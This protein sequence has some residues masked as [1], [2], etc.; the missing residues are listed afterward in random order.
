MIEVWVFAA[1]GLRFAVPLILAAMAGLQSERSGVVNIALE[2]K[3]LNGACFAAL[4]GVIFQNPLAA[5]AG[6]ILGAVIL[7]ALHFWLTQSF[8]MDHIISGM[9]INA[10]ALGGT[11]ILS[12]KA[13]ALQGSTRVPSLP[14]EAFWVIALLTVIGIGWQLGATKGGLRLLAVGNDPDKARQMGVD[15]WPVRLK[16]LLWTGVFCGIAGA[17]L[18]ATA[19]S[20]SKEMTSGRGF[21]ALAALILAGWRPW[22]ALAACLVFG[23]VQ[24]LQL[25]LQNTKVAGFEFPTELFTALPYLVTVLALAFM[26]RNTKA[27]AGLGRP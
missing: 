27:P 10:L 24:N 3:M 14:E 2:G 18:V 21:I 6:G 17:L 11:R 20:F 25:V 4:F 7:S 26:M 12:E 19:G 23:L 16:A 5:L 8:R 15:P 1:S 22:P 13:P 9:G